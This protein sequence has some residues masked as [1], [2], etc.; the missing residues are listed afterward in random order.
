MG[1]ESMYSN[2]KPAY[3]AEVGKKKKKQSI[4]FLADSEVR[5]SLSIL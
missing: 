1:N 5:D 3:I 2:I 4:P